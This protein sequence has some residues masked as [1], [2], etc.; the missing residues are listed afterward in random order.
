MLVV[1]VVVLSVVVHVV[2]L[3]TVAL[4][5]VDEHEEIIAAAIVANAPSTGPM[6]AGFPPATLRK[7]IVSISSIVLSLMI[8]LARESSLLLS[9]HGFPSFNVEFVL[10]RL[11]SRLQGV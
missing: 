6:T 11:R 8:G 3:V 7:S 2:V 5:G 4:F 1:Q 10:V 9:V